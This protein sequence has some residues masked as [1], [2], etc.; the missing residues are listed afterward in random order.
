VSDLQRDL[1]RVTKQRDAAETMGRRLRHELDT[2]RADRD[3]TKRD[4]DAEIAYRIA[5]VRERDAV[6][7]LLDAALAEHDRDQQACET[8][9]ARVAQLR[10]ELD[11]ARAEGDQYRRD[12]VATSDRAAELAARVTQVE[13][14][15]DR[16]RTALDELRAP[17]AT[18][19]DGPP[20]DWERGVLAAIDRQLTA[21]PAVPDDE[22]G[23]R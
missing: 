12:F 6:V 9:T 22:R 20:E 14:E 8:A 5:V 19:I 2:L 10:Q 21:V 23:E 3:L 7:V 13:T 4:L 11:G 15:R 18:Q 1:A 17:R 16:L